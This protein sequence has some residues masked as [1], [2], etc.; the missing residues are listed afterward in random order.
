MRPANWPERLADVVRQWRKQPF[1][2]GQSDC[3]HFAC[4]VLTAVSGRDWTVLDLGSYR[5]RRA[6]MDEL[7]RLGF[8]DLTDAVTALLGPAQK[9]PQRGDLVSIA[10]TQGPALGVCLGPC[11]AA[12][13]PRGLVFLPLS[14][15]VLCWRV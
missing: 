11:L 2:W 10:T 13:G 7:Q 5:S 8:S 9:N 14:R 1:V 12:M 15:T 3:V 6:A 4:A